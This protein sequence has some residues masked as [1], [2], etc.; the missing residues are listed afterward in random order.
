[1]G[2]KI[3]FTKINDDYLAPASDQDREEFLKLKT[4][5]IYQAEIVH[6]RN[7]YFHRK[8]LSLFRLGFDHW[9]PEPLTGKFEKFGTPEKDFD[10][11]RKDILIA[12]GHRTVVANIV[13][14]EVSYKAESISFAN[15]DEIKFE[16][17]YSNLANYFIANVLEGYTAETLDQ[18]IEKIL[19]GYT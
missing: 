4:G 14:G 2:K 11:F 17:V 5:K 3:F 19:N 16:E 6:P 13:T 12:C 18:V 1:M 10:S 15:M 9:Q 7:I 8:V